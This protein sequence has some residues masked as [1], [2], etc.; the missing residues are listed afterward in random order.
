MKRIAMLA[1]A[2]AT[3]VLAGSARAAEVEVKLL[4]K[5]GDGAP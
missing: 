3:L 4:N 2:A 5:G 1:A